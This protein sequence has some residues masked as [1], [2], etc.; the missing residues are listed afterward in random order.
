MT[1]T[2]YLALLV[3]L[4]QHKLIEGYATEGTM[5]HAITIR[6]SRPE[7]G[8]ALHRLAA[9]DDSPAPGGDALLA[10]VDG[11]LAAARSLAPGAR[12]V[13]DPFRRTVDVL[14]LLDL[15]AA[16]ERTG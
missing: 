16:Q 13:A 4:C 6:H 15:R 11:R 2:G 9:L 12:A 8:R 5:S 14:A 1:V 10:F 7:D 3:L